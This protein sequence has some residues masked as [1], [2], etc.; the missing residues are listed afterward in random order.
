VEERLVLVGEGDVYYDRSGD[1]EE[2]CPKGA[3]EEPGIFGCKVLE[4]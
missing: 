3:A 4:Y 1:G 2:A